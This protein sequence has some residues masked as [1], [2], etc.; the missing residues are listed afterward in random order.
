MLHC[1]AVA[2]FV[3]AGVALALAA[4]V[5]GALLR[6]QPAPPAPVVRPSLPTPPPAVSPERP[7][8]A[9]V[10]RL[11]ARVLN[12]RHPSWTLDGHSVG[13]GAAKLEL[14]GVPAG[15]HTLQV[16]AGGRKPREETITIEPHQTR[17]IEWMLS[18]AAN[19]PA[20]AA[21]R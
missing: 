6:R 8:E 3:Y 1:F 13:N 5:A 2:R 4:I 17:A 14:D 12:A 10:G 21:P 7:P 20:A 15:A 16:E 11:E 19:S 9:A 18:P